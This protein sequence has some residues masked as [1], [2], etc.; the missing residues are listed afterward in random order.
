MNHYKTAN[1]RLFFW[2]LMSLVVFPVSSWGQSEMSLEEVVQRYL[3]SDNS[4]EFEKIDAV[5]QGD[6]SF[7]DMDRGWFHDLEEILR[8]GRT[9]YPDVEEKVDGAFP[10]QEIMVE[11]PEGE[12]VPVFVQ[13]PPNYSAGISWPVMFAMHGGPP[14]SV[15]GA[16][17]S[18]RRMINV[19]E[20]SAAKFGWIVAS[21]SMAT[22]VSQGR[23][24]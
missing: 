18:A 20:S 5:L 10:L 17:S 22:T 16:R 8:R 23:R 14:G 2:A 3:W 24:T 19:W 13:L 11:L 7:G 1:N 4:S 9:D 6:K 21:P 15:A 12:Q